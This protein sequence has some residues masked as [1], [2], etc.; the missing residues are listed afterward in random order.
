[1]L[2]QN[3]QLFLEL[4]NAARL[5]P[6]GEAE[7]QG[8][9]LNEGLDAGTIPDTPVQPLAAN[10]QIQEAAAGH[11]QWMLD[12]DTFSH[13]G[14]GGSTPGERMSAAGY[15]FEGASGWGENIALWR[16]TGTVDLQAAI[17]QHHDML[18]E[19]P[20]HRENLFRSYFRE[21][22]ISQQRG[23]FEPGWD[24]SMLTHKFGL[25]G[26]KVF[27]TGVIFDDSDANNA[28]SIGEGLGDF[29]VATEST[30]TMTW[31]AGGYSLGIDSNPAVRVTL[32]QGETAMDVIVDLSGDN[33][34]LDLLNGTRIL[35]SGDV[36]LADGAR[37][38][39]MLG[40]VDNT[41]I[42]NAL[43][44]RFYIGHGDNTLMG[45]NGLDRAVFTGLRSD[46]IITENPNG[47]MTVADQRSD[48]DSD[49][50]NT[51]SEV[52]YLVFSDT[53]L[54]LQEQPDGITISGQLTSTHGM[55]IGDTALRFSLTD[56]TE[57]MLSTDETGG[58]SLIL[59]DGQEGHL[60][61]AQG[62][63]ANSQ[64]GVTDALDIL[65]LAV[66]LTPSFGPATP[67]DMIAADVDFSGDIKVDD[68]LNTLRAAVGLETGSASPGA[69]VLLDPEQSL[70]TV[71]V[72][73]VSYSRGMSVTH[74]HA[75]SQL[76][77]DV[78]TLG[79]LGA[80]NAV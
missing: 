32:G 23:E 25:S 71:T 40:A 63:V 57:R 53:I 77:L 19:S 10:V 21:T 9:A 50:T 48:P 31:A 34:K 55:S 72:D 49:G 26:S 22:G 33:V 70:T 30:A 14:A 69:Y 79:D 16:T 8:I 2:T 13:T 78:I 35:T 46:Y 5:D 58:F 47:S 3:E 56:G 76:D 11:S 28:Y 65:R 17:T 15:P 36:T 75:G 37:D 64:P 41:I 29:Q 68:A 43:D 60:S 67:H 39:E 7:R 62:A 61:M 66:G 59:P 4:V 24:A 45:G 52:E 80:L 74:D 12:T 42:G 44:N 38:V 20:G 18:Y 27:L 51:L 1:M 6:R 73:N 54:D